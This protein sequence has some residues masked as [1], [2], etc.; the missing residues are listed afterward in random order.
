MRRSV[1]SAA[2]SFLAVSTL[3]AAAALAQPALTLPQSSPKASISQTVGL[4]EMAIRYHR[5]AVNKRTVWGDLVPYDEVWR[6]GANENTTI[7]FS[8]PVTVNGKPLPAGTYG[9]HMIP[10]RGDWTVAF[11]TV[12]VAWGSFSY[13]EKEDALRVTVKPKAAE[14]QERLSYSFD[15]PTDKSVTVAM[16]WEKVEVPFTVEVDTP[17]V[18]VASLRNELRGLPRF[19]WQGWNGA[20]AYAMRNKV[21]L[22][23]ALTWVDRSISMQ[24]NFTNLRT[25]AGILE[26]KGDA[27]TAA[28]LREKAMKAATEADINLYGYQL[29]GEGKTDAAIEIFRKNVKD[30]PQS[31]NTYDSL[32][33][34]YDKKGDKKLA[35]ENYRRAQNM[36]KDPEQKKRIAAILAKMGA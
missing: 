4:T 8:T 5:P 29:L 28:E 3:S 6:A 10:T 21:N 19:G 34:A 18:V 35:A 2:V 30:Y 1:H 14:F 20:A 22:D 13:D 12:N 17:S 9:L 31:W 26:A 24:E 15:D 32:G 25:K 36:T 23:E 16:H 7:S 11:S 33:E 27:K